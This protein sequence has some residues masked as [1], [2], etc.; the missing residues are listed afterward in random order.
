MC[1]VQPPEYC[2]DGQACAHSGIGGEGDLPLGCDS[3]WHSGPPLWQRSST[4]CL[5]PLLCSARDATHSVSPTPTSFVCPSPIP[6]SR[7]DLSFSG[8]RSF[9]TPYSSIDLLGTGM[10]GSTA[11]MPFLSALSTLPRVGGGGVPA[12]FKMVGA[13]F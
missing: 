12:F 10:A 3:Q 7:G 13:S 11:D 4:P 9:R 6:R 2:N 5:S 1:D 8:R